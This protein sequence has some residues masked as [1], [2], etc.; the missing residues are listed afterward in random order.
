MAQSKIT[1]TNQD[2]L[3]LKLPH[4]YLTA[5]EVGKTSHPSAN[6]IRF[7]A[8]KSDQKGLPPPVPLHNDTISFNDIE[9]LADDVLPPKGDNSSWA[10]TRRSPYLTVTWTEEQPTVPQLWLVAYALVSLHPLVEQFRICFDGKDSEALARKLYATGLFHAHPKPSNPSAAQ[11]GHLLSRSTFWQGAASPF[12][13]RPVWAPH[14][15]ALGKPTTTHYPSFPYQVSPSTDFPAVPRHTWHPV[16]EPK[17]EPGSIIYS[18]WIPHLKEHFTMIA[19]DYTNPDHLN[20]F[21]KWQNDPRVAA[22]WNE[23]GTLD[24]HREYLRKLHEDPHVLTMFAAF[25]GVLFAYYEVYWAMV[26]SSL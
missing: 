13:P 16:R 17:P 15:D 26:S 11:D 19:L 7:S 25:D 6:Q 8:T 21:H 18:R 4:P 22:G 23:T 12:G 2:G 24:E 14:L 10:R 9:Y 20:L 1:V 3:L 5:Y